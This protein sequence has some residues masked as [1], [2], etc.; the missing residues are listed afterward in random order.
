VAVALG[1]IAATVWIVWGPVRETRAVSGAEAAATRA[2][3]YAPLERYLLAH[4]GG[5]ARVEV[6]LTRSH[7][8]AALLA[9]TVSLARGWEKQLEERY[10]QV[11]LSPTLNAGSYRSW[12]TRE[13]VAYVALAD[14]PPDPSSA[15]EGR[16]IRAGLPYL[17]EV[18][19]SAHWRLYAVQGAT[20]LLSGPG[21]L[22]ALGGD[23]FALRA[24]TPGEL[25]ARVRYTRYFTVTA[26]AACLGE[27]PGGWTYVHARAPG[28]IVVAARFSL[29]RA[30]GLGASCQ[31]GARP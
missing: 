1:A 20:P 31:R 25:V 21:A 12:L 22:T 23:S 2:S 8:E 24:H 4:G 18:F 15:A 7:W 14:V 11:L 6:P 3:Y 27:A 9:P 29:G 17:R 28:R 5:L 19:V 26:G 30:L 13:A 16:L 10:D